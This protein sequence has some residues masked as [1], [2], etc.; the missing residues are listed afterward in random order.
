MV[1]WR[2]SGDDATILTRPLTTTLANGG[3]PSGWM[4]PPAGTTT[5]RASS[6]SCISDGVGTR[7]RNDSRTAAAISGS[8]SAAP[9]GL[10]PGRGCGPLILGSS[11]PCRR[12]AAGWDALATG[13]RCVDSGPGQQNSAIRF[14][15]SELSWPGSSGPRAH[16][17]IA[18][19]GL[20]EL[21]E[22]EVE[23][24]DARQRLADR[25]ERP[26]M[27]GRHAQDPERGPV[28]SGRV[29]GVV[30][31]SVARIARREAGHQ[32]IANHLGD[33]RGARDGVDRCIAV[34]DRVVGAHGGLEPGDRQAVDH[35]VVV[36]AEPGDRPAHREVRGMVDVEPV[37][38]RDGGG[39]DAHRQGAAPD[40]GRER[41]PLRW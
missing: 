37:N 5:S 40:L 16:A 13:D 35:D 8:S 39:T 34:H 26:P 6:S 24:L 9:D 3:P 4:T 32:A 7:P 36:P 11:W 21:V 14:G 31:P 18:A 33:H 23:L 30:L 27:V 22:L 28:L 12:S 25:R 29:A 19:R 2:P 17:R 15:G 20:A 1:A 38:L 41:L 10:A